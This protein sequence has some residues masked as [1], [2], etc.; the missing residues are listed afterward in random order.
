MILPIGES[1]W[2]KLDG[3][4]DI[5]YSYTRSSQVSQL[6]VNTTTT[7]RKPA[8]DAQV[9]ASA[10]ITQNGDEGSRDDRATAPGLVHPVSRPALVDRRRR[11]I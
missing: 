11:I 3:S 1:F 10:T 9:S 7:F 6:N 8:F 2:K 5:G 4:I